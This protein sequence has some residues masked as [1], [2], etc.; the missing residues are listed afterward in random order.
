MIL[1]Y[2]V[3]TFISINYVSGNYLINSCI[4]GINGD[5]AV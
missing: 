1:A 5:I 4:L 2:F 3:Q